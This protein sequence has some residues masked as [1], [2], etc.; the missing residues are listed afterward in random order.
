MNATPAP[1]ARLIVVEVVGPEHTDAVAR[2]IVRLDDV[3][4]ATPAYDDGFGRI[5]QLRLQAVT[6]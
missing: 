3:V 4:S 6:R 5:V 1:P 2:K